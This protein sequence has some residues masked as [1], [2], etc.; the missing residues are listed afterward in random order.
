MLRNPTNRKREAFDPMHCMC[1]YQSGRLT[2]NCCLFLFS[3]IPVC[4]ERKK[5]RKKY[6]QKLNKN[7]NREAF[8]LIHCSFDGV[9]AHKSFSIV[10]V[11]YE[12]F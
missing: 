10:P 1:M 6:A 12:N 9:Y 2:S 4:S 11:E 5:E 3:F 7:K 8:D